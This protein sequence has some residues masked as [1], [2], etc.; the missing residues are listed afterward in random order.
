M[1]VEIIASLSDASKKF[2]FNQVLTDINLNVKS[3][4]ILGLIGPIDSGKTTCVRC[5]I[6]LEDLTGGKAF[7]LNEKIPKRKLLDKIGYMG[8]ETALYETLT[9]YE[10]MVCFGKL[11][12]L[13]GLEL[14]NEIDKNLKLVELQDAADRTVSK[15]SKDMKRRL[16]LAIT[17]LGDP[18]F[19][20]LDEPTVDIEPKLRLSIW[21]ELRRRAEA[22]A[23]VIVTTH[24]MSE[25]LQCDKV[26][27][28]VE[29]KILAEGTPEELMHEF[30]AS[31]IEEVIINMEAI[32]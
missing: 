19:I 24:V 12:H 16:S 28:L 7:V 13:K 3:G 5:M 11:K 17:L 32:T 1:V 23:G 20:V 6:G 26:A 29:G 15:L 2:F 21:S 18:Q 30:N 8:Q 10:N 31:S 4:E 9:A 22:G 27:L 14:K 25:A